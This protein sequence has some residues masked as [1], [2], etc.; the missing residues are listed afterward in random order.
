MREFHS[1]LLYSEQLTVYSFY[2]LQLLQIVHYLLCTVYSSLKKVDSSFIQALI[3]AS[4]IGAVVET[5][6]AINC[7]GTTEKG[8]R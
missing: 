7:S 6:A 8:N 3:L 5:I 1:L 4:P 2:S